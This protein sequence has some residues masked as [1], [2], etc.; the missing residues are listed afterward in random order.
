MSGLVGSA[1]IGGSLSRSLIAGMIGSN[2]PIM[3]FVSG[4]TTLFL[5]FPQVA[6]ILAPMPKAVLAAI[7]LAAVLPGV[8][9]PKDVLKLKGMDIFVGW[10]TTIGSCAMDPTKGFFLGVLMYAVTQAP[11]KVLGSGKKKD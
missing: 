10:G 7:V 8:V 5:A 4:I 3:G 2:S 6:I 9:Y 1:P 11:G